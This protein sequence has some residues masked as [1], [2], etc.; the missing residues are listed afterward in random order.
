MKVGLAALTDMQ[1]VVLNS[2]KA[3]AKELG[4]TEFSHPTEE[5]TISDS[6]K[7]FAEKFG[8]TE[9]SYIVRTNDIEFAEGQIVLIAGPHGTTV[10]VINVAV[11]EPGLSRQTTYLLNG[12]VLFQKRQRLRDGEWVTLF[13]PDLNVPINA[14]LYVS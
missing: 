14:V 3:L 11:E 7:A 2:G 8:L 13:G 5:I 4:L 10:G 6:D 9:S 12:E 1:R